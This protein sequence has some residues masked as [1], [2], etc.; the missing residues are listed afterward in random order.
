MQKIAD[1]VDNGAKRLECGVSRRFGLCG[2][3]CS[4]FQ[5]C[6]S[7]VIRLT[8]LSRI[9]RRHSK[10]GKLRRSP[11]LAGHAEEAHG[12]SRE[13]GTPFRA[14]GCRNGTSLGSASGGSELAAGFQN[15]VS[16]IRNA[17]PVRNWLE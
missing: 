16:A 15:T 7:G 6:K 14:Y 11:G 13:S 12:A 1:R 9:I 2:E 3:D 5:I 17:L 4:S 8:H 10:E